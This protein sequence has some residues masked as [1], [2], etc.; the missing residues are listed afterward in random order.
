MQTFL[1]DYNRAY[2]DLKRLIKQTEELAEKIQIVDVEMLDTKENDIDSAIAYQKGFAEC[3]YVLRML[4]FDNK[5]KLFNEW[6][7]LSKRVK[8]IVLDKKFEVEEY[9]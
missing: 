4:S 9:D 2:D 3:L 8:R 5:S 7:C 1:D 6:D